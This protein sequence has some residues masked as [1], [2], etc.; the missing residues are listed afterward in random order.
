MFLAS[1][2]SGC[3]C[4]YLNTNKQRV[5]ISPPKEAFQKA[6]SASVSVLQMPLTGTAVNYKLI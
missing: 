6:P 4:T 3:I 2:L 1:R 5:F